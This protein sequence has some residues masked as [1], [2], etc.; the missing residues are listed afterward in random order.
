MHVYFFKNEYSFA[1][2]LYRYWYWQDPI[3][4]GGVLGIVITLA[5]GHTTVFVEVTTIQTDAECYGLL[6]HLW[7][8]LVVL[9]FSQARFLLFGLCSF[10]V[11]YR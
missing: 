1:L 9:K 4:L 2:F 5:T 7:Q 3:I 10:C 11:R 8:E 6:R